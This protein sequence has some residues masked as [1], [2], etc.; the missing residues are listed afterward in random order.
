MERFNFTFLSYCCLR[1]FLLCYLDWFLFGRWLFSQYHDCCFL[2]CWTLWRCKELGPGFW[3]Q[4]Y[5]IWCGFAEYNALC[6]LQ[7]RCNAEC[8]E[9]YE[10]NGWS[11]NRS[12]SQY[13]SYLDQVFLQRER[14]PA[15]LPYNERHAQQ[16]PQTRRG[17]EIFNKSHLSVIMVHYPSSS[18]PTSS[19]S[20]YCTESQPCLGGWHEVYNVI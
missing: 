6:L 16:R 13:V 9:N 3:S 1:T 19:S 8:N 14:I 12:W 7:S 18:S 15:C 4:V 10:K 2:P 20:S 5:K 17:L 11:L